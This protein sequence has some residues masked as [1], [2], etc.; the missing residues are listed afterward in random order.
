MSF[1][2]WES[3][4]EFLDSYRPRAAQK[5]MARAVEKALYD[6]EILLAEAGTGTGK[7]LAYLIPPS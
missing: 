3:L 7:T 2:G 6:H 4:G 1:S 5:S